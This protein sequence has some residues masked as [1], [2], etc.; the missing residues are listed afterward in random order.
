VLV[1]TLGVVL[2]GV[3]LPLCAA[4]GSRKAASATLNKPILVRFISTIL[5]SPFSSVSGGQL[6][7]IA[8]TRR[9][10]DFSQ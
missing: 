7:L 5:I 8:A 9:N 1:G 2:L 6:Q 3:V 4:A 10:P